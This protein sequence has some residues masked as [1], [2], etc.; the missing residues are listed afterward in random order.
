LQ[1]VQAPA[2]QPPQLFEAQPFLYN[3][4]N[5]YQLQEPIM[6]SEPLLSNYQKIVSQPVQ[7]PQLFAAYP[8]LQQQ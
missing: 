2:Y 1:Q 5:F 7:Q 6:G 8:T 4:Q 3:N